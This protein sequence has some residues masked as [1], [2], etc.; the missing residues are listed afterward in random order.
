MEGRFHFR[1]LEPQGQPGGVTFQVGVTTY[2]CLYADV[3]FKVEQLIGRPDVRRLAT[4]LA[5]LVEVDSHVSIYTPEHS[6]SIISMNLE[7]FFT[8]ASVR[9]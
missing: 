9:G 5:V 7:V 3:T 6:E 8:R 4:R 2:E 1:I